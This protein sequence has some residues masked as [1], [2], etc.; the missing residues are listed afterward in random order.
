MRRFRILLVSITLL[1][2]LIA[3]AAVTASQRAPEAASPVTIDHALSCDLEFPSWYRD[4]AS[5]STPN[6]SQSR[7]GAKAVIDLPTTANGWQVCDYNLRLET[8]GPFAYV[9]IEPRNG[10][11]GLDHNGLYVGIITCDQ[12]NPPVTFCWGDE[13]PPH[14]FTAVNACGFTTIQ[15]H[16]EADFAAH[17]YAVYLNT[18]G[19]WRMSINGS[20]KRT[21]RQAELCWQA[22]LRQAVYTGG[23]RDT[24]DSYGHSYT[25]AV[26][27]TTIRDAFYGVYN[28][29]WLAN[30]FL[31]QAGCQWDQP[32]SFCSMPT[33]TDD[34]IWLW[35]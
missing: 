6:Q 15:D 14:Y 30:P 28:Q 3:P 29:G 8:A 23:K 7:S 13:S 10:C 27:R 35:E 25:S 31:G 32:N 5:N 33:G 26:Y 4:G 11:C 22:D 19:I 9:G 1:A 24:G 20:I 12:Y 34:E 16:G 2:G 17:E 18:D 21:A